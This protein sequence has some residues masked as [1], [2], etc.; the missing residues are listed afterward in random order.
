MSTPV[1]VVMFTLT[2]LGLEWGIKFQ[3]IAFEIRP[4]RFGPAV[5]LL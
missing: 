4:N 3:Y 1:P 2:D 5:H